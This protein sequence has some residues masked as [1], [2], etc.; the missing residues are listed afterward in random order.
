MQHSTIF[1]R[2]PRVKLKSGLGRVSIYDGAR[3]GT[4]PPPLK[5]GTRASAWLEHEVEAVNAAR[6]AGKSDDE[7]RELVEK[8]VAARSKA[9]A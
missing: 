1:L 2:L 5:I 7:I 6:V 3:K 8:L 9:A 4:F